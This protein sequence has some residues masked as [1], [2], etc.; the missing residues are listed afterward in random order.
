MVDLT[1][2]MKAGMEEL[3]KLVEKYPSSIPVLAAADF[4]HVR[5]EALRASIDQGRCPFGLCW[6]LGERK[7]YKIP[8]LTF[9]SWYL[10][11][12]V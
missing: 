1:K 9:C 6:S 7:A 4:L 10:S 3:A 12:P 8:T 2:I 5:P 11:H